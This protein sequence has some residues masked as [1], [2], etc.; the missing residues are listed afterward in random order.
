MFRVGY[1]YR[2]TIEEAESASEELKKIKITNPKPKY[3]QYPDLR[4]IEIVK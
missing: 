2:P 3:K 1:H 4:T